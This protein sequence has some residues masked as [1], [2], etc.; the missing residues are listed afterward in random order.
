[1]LETMKVL[2]PSMQEQELSVELLDL[3]RSLVASKTEGIPGE[4]AAR[5]QQFDYYLNQIFSVCVEKVEHVP[6]MF[7]NEVM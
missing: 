7:L 5:E 1:E 4:I 2:V 6:V 3:L